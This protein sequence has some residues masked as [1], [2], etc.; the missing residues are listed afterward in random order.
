MNNIFDN[1]INDLL[2]KYILQEDPTQDAK[3]LEAAAADLKKP[4][5]PKRVEEA[6]KDRL[7][8]A[9]EKAAG[10]SQSAIAD[11]KFHFASPAYHL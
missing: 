9:A 8:K 4:I 7:I 11:Q 3:E 6:K 5:D 1:A 10:K 2:K